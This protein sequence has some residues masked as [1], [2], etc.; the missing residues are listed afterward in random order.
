MKEKAYFYTCNAVSHKI[1]VF[2]N[3]GWLNQLM[4]V[5]KK[6]HW[7][8][9]NQCGVNWCKNQ[10]YSTAQK[11]IEAAMFNSPVYQL[12]TLKELAEFIRL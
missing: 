4:K 3:I 10:R 12:D 5:G 2:W 9:L 8:S 6:Y 1:Y 11:A 7:I